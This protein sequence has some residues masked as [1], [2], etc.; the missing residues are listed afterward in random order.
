LTNGFVSGSPR[1]DGPL[2]IGPSRIVPSIPVAESAKRIPEEKSEAKTRHRKSA[3]KK[4][5][6]TGLITRSSSTETRNCARKIVK[7]TDKKSTIA[8]GFYFRR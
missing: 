1:F 2:W 4:H 7:I 5:G 3:N 6:C 8:R